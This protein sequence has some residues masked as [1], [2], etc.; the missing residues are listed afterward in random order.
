MVVMVVVIILVAVMVLVVI[1]MNF[2]VFSFL[3][4]FL[5]SL[6]LLLSPFFL[7]LKIIYR[8][9]NSQNDLKSILFLS[10]PP[11]QNLP[12]NLN[13]FFPPLFSNL[14]PLSP[15][16][17]LLFLLLLLLPLLLFPL[18][19]SLFTLIIDSHTE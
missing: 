11:L 5:F 9:N 15:I 4:L 14:S 10:P 17:L 6:S 16:F 13:A 3:F 12:N 8:E 19:L 7:S 18:S 1:M 2:F